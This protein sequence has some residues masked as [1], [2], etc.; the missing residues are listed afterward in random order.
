MIDDELCDRN[1]FIDVGEKLV[2]E[3]EEGL[4]VDLSEKSG[5]VLTVLKDFDALML[6]I[7]N[8]KKVAETKVRVKFQDVENGRKLV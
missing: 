5:A 7:Q 6:E 8:E 1:E 3:I 4:N 2:G